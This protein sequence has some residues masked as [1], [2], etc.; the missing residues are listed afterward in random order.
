MHAIRLDS[1]DKALLA[2]IEAR[3]GQHMAGV[4]RGFKLRRGSQSHA[5]IR[6]LATGGFV[7]LD[8]TSQRGRVFCHL[9]D[10]GKKSLAE[11]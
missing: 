8:R 5:R 2:A 6:Q 4:L 9:T 1:I 10:A 7:K 3:P 11:A